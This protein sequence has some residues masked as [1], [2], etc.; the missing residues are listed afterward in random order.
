MTVD[1][2]IPAQQNPL[3]KSPN[4]YKFPG[5]FRKFPEISGFLIA[6]KS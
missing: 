4:F 6:Q 5:N 1:N 2:R 3:T